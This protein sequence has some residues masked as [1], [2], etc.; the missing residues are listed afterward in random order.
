MPEDGYH[1]IH[2]TLHAAGTQ[3]ENIMNA[4]RACNALAAAK[5][6]SC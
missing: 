1:C 5:A 3:E 2:L 4:L 6:L